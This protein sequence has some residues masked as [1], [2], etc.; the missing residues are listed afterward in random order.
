MRR[1]ALAIALIALAGSA[2]ADQPISTNYNFQGHSIYGLPAPLVLSS[3]LLFGSL[4]VGPCVLQVDGSRNQS[5]A[6]DLLVDLPIEIVLGHL[7]LHLD[8]TTIGSTGTALQ[9]LGLTFTGDATGTM[10]A[11]STSVALILGANVVTAAKI[12]QFPGLSLLGVPGSSTANVS[13]LTFTANN[14]V[15]QM[16]GGTLQAHALDYSQLTGTPA[17]L[18]PSGAAGGDLAGSTYPNPVIAANVVAVAKM[19]QLT[20]RSVL[21]VPGASQ[22]NMA[23]ITSTTPGDALWNNAGTVGF[24]PYPYA[25]LSGLPTL[26]YQTVTG[27]AQEPALDFGTA[28]ATGLSANDNAGVSTQVFNTLVT[29]LAGGQTIIG[30]TNASDNLTLLSTGNSTKG[31]F[32]F[33]DP[34][35]FLHT[36][37]TTHAGLLQLGGFAVLYGGSISGLAAGLH[38]GGSGGPPITS[39]IFVGVNVNGEQQVVMQNTSTGA[40]GAASVVAGTVNGGTRLRMTMFGPNFTSAGLY[41]PQGGLLELNDG[42]LGGSGN[43]TINVQQTAGGDIVLATQGVPRWLVLFAGS[44]EGLERAAPSTP[45]STFEKIWPDST[46]HNIASMNPSGTKTYMAQV[47]AGTTHHFLTS[48]AATGAFGD[49]QPVE[50][51][52]TNLVTDLA[53]K[54]ATG[55]YLT[56]LSSA[57][58]ATGP[59]TPTATVHLDAGS[60]VQGLLPLGNLVNCATGQIVG[61]IGGVEGCV[62]PTAGT[63]YTGT[64]PIIVNAGTHDIS[65]P[66]CG[67][68]SGSVT[69]VFGTAG[70]ILVTPSTPNPVVSLIAKGAGAGS[71][72]GSGIAG[73]S[74]DAFG[75]V[76]SVTTATY[77][78]S[79]GTTPGTYNNLTVAASGLITGASVTSWMTAGAIMKSGGLAALPVAAVAGTDYQ[80]AVAYPT[81]ADILLSPG[82]TG[83]N[84]VGDSH[85]T[86]DPATHVMTS[87]AGSV[88]GGSVVFSGGAGAGEVLLGLA[89]SG[90]YEDVFPVGGLTLSGGVLFVT[91][92]PMAI[93][94]YFNQSGLGAYGPEWLP[95]S[96]SLPNGNV[97]EYPPRFAVTSVELALNVVGV[98]WV[99]GQTLNA[100]VTR[101]GSAVAGAD[102]TLSGSSPALG[103]HLGAIITVSGAITDTY[104]VSITTTGGT[105]A[106]LSFTAELF[107]G[108]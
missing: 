11:G 105:G 51:D 86:L 45:A 103:P 52:V 5:C 37:T 62:T 41:G 19:Q 29:G 100:Q 2:H 26:H 21:G 18:P 35:V 49:A 10:G 40:A 46:F 88:L 54:Q 53:G 65:C 56:G 30:G 101:N 78:T 17:A 61:M 31:N 84:P 1:I 22:A 59:G 95:T 77:L 106:S 74:L 34:A 58:T 93:P 76:L 4:P 79:T 12:Q 90:A 75:S 25:S 87:S 99:G 9:R 27:F 71:Y 66:T 102:V 20:G 63:V 70:Q 73:F 44:L 55:N 72:G 108:H 80:A 68:S 32:V 107:L 43:L 64:S 50:A 48:F 81:A 39:P 28:S 33:D 3:P 15:A 92:P 67:T 36:S 23:A 96:N 13:A 38:I 83:G 104:G 82:G 7:V 97:N 8:G 14:Q 57:V 98:S 6:T 94:F 91:L 69:G 24:G 60:T 42:G 16:L 47:D 89:N 85:F